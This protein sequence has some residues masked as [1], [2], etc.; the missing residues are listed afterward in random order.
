MK[1]VLFSS[2]EDEAS[3]TSSSSSSSQPNEVHNAESHLTTS[4]DDLPTDDSGSEVS[5]EDISDT[6]EDESQSAFE[7]TDTNSEDQPFEERLKNRQQNGI[8]RCK[9]L[10]K[11]KQHNHKTKSKRHAPKELSSRRSDYF[12]RGVP[13]LANSG[14]A[15][16]ASISTNRFKA[17]D[18][19]KVLLIITL[20]S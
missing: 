5:H 8:F 20:L 2:T 14:I 10:K 15:T 11:S 7:E 16:E 17:R 3:H 18:P 13:L 4:F 9:K 6:S 12:R 1:P 19:I